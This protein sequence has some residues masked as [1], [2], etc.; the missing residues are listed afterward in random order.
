M[1]DVTS[2][3]VVRGHEVYVYI[4]GRL[5]AKIWNGRTLAVF[6]GISYRTSSR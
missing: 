4:L 5:V 3:A 1:V 2:F 6:N